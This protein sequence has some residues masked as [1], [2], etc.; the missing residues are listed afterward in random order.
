MLINNAGY[1]LEGAFE[2]VPMTDIRRQFETDVFG[3]IAMTKLVLPACAGSDGAAWSIR[4]RW[5]ATSPSPAA[6]TIMRPSTRSKRSATRLRFEVKGFGID[7]IVVEPGPIKT[8]FGDTAVGSIATLKDSPYPP[9]TRCSKNKSA[10][11]TQAARWPASPPRR[12]RS[13]S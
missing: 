9:S 8:R 10:K 4:A 3:L 1:G 5:A 6:R 12:K 11:H 13:P 7:V 2:E